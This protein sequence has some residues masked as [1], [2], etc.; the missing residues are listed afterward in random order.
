[1]SLA[2][3][4]EHSRQSQRSQTKHELATNLGGQSPSHRSLACW[5]L[6][7]LPPLQEVC[8]EMQQENIQKGGPVARVAGVEELH[9]NQKRSSIQVNTD[10]LAAGEKSCHVVQRLA[11]AKILPMLVALLARRGQAI[12]TVPSVHR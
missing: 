1:M 6:F 9:E 2:H 4:V 8:R 11:A 5:L 3:F 12:R 10:R 7:R